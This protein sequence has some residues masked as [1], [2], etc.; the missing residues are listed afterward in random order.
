M[1]VVSVLVNSGITDRK[2][3]TTAGSRE[4]MVVAVVAVVVAVVAAV[5]LFAQSPLAMVL[6]LS[7]G[8]SPDAISAADGGRRIGESVTNEKK[9]KPNSNETSAIVNV[10]NFMRMIKSN[11]GEIYLMILIVCINSAA[12]MIFIA[13]RKE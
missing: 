10:Y 6:A 1:P 5:V 13:L 9:V 2:L 8:E 3:L 4:A 11:E 12:E 7:F